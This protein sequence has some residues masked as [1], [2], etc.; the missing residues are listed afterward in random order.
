MRIILLGMPGA[1]KG[2]QAQFLVD[3]FQIPQISTGDMLR[4]EVKAGTA[5]GMEAKKFM[6]SGNLVPDQVVIEMTKHRV[7]QPDCKNGFIIDGFP[8]TIAQAEA[9]S[10]AGIDIDYVVEI[11]VADDEILRRMSGRRTHPGSGRTYHIDFNPPKVPGKDDVTGEPLIQRPDD[12]PETVKKRIDNYHAQTKPLVNYY[13]SRAES[14][15]K[16]AP[17]Y[18]N[19][20]G[21]GSVEHIRDKII[22]ALVQHPANEPDHGFHR[23]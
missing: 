3:R 17:R 6:D 7:T 21:R 8:R 12:N 23:R 10:T 15:D 18:V 2:T 14:G 22:A 1:G 16:R 19:V 4:A 5:L 20:Y 9:L 11:E 13:L